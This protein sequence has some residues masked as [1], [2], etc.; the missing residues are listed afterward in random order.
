[1]SGDNSPSRN[2]SE[3]DRRSNISAATRISLLN[4]YANAPTPPIAIHHPKPL[5]PP[6]PTHTSPH[7]YSP[8]ISIFPD[9]ST[10]SGQQQRLSTSRNTSPIPWER[11][12]IAI[13]GRRSEVSKNPKL[14]SIRMEIL[15]SA[16]RRYRQG[17]IHSPVFVSDE[18]ENLF[19]GYQA[20]DKL[21]KTLIIVPPRHSDEPKLFCLDRKDYMDL[22]EELERRVK[23]ARLV[24]GAHIR[25]LPIF[26]NNHEVGLRHALPHD[27]MV[28]KCVL[29]REEI[30]NWFAHFIAEIQRVSATN[31][32]SQSHKES[33]PFKQANDESPSRENRDEERISRVNTGNVK[34]RSNSKDF[35]REISPFEYNS[36]HSERIAQNSALPSPSPSENFTMIT[37]HRHADVISRRSSQHQETRSVP[38]QITLTPPP[39]CELSIQHAKT[40]VPSRK[41]DNPAYIKLA[42]AYSPPETPRAP[43]NNFDTVRE[44]TKEKLGK[45][46]IPVPTADTRTYSNLNPLEGRTVARRLTE[47][48]APPQF[49]SIPPTLASLKK[50]RQRQSKVSQQQHVTPTSRHSRPSTTPLGAKTAAAPNDPDNGDSSDSTEP[51]RRTPIPPSRIPSAHRGNN[52]PRNPTPGYNGNGPGG[53]RGPR[54]PG[55]PSG[56][57]GPGGP[58]GP[59]NP[60]NRRIKKSSSSDSSSD[61]Y[62]WLGQDLNGNTFRYRTVI[63]KIKLKVPHFDMKIKAEDVDT[64]NGNTEK[65]VEWME[66]VTYLGERS[67]LVWKQLG[68]LVPTRFRR[69]AKSW[70]QS[71]PLEQRRL[72]STDWGTLRAE[73]RNYYMDRVWQD[74]Q[75]LKAKN[76]VYRDSTAPQEKPTDYFLWKFRLLRT[77]E[78]FTK[79]EMIMAIMDGAPQSW[80]SIIDT[81]L[82]DTTEQLQDQIKFHEDSLINLPNTTSETSEIEKRLRDLEYRTNVLE[83]D[84]REPGTPIPAKTNRAE[85]KT[86]KR[87]VRSGTIGKAR[88]YAIGWSADLGPPPFPKEDGIVSKGRTPEM[89]GVRPCRHCGSK[90]HWDNECKYVRKGTSYMKAKFPNPSIEYIVAQAEYEEAYLNAETDDDDDDNDD[91][92]NSDANSD[93]DEESSFFDPGS[94]YLH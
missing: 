91:V 27:E 7:P 6:Q 59:K 28:R 51:S 36:S 32:P 63:K 93:D 62:S 35:K 66:S 85:S 29:F 21:M 50:D 34:E 70:W 39:T 94:K 77:A 57:G 47:V 68:E 71:L 5:Y 26:G 81:S 79:S 45:P 9:T 73:I 88:T 10:Y 76:C 49:H 25:N 44:P 38:P 84:D 24:Y 87:D 58:G 89:L 15:Q 11:A 46:V 31:L 60:R 86:K 72:A 14:Q 92:S 75:K 18:I 19:P 41:L 90:N 30:E 52:T 17:I 82:V 69:K 33:T 67:P 4:K 53:P 13:A 83:T 74:K 16:I 78:N 64:W 22:M 65:L 80:N 48:F 56:P 61:M 23:E 1:M 20:V 43:Q 40:E 54:S 2:S 12:N 42:T 3:L 8:Y 55:G 37:P